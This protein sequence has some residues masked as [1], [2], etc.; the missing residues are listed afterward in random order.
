MVMLRLFRDLWRDAASY[1]TL[2]YYVLVVLCWI[3]YHILP[4]SKRWIALL[5]GS[6]FFYYLA[7]DKDLRTMAVLAASILISYLGGIL[8]SG[9]QNTGTR[10]AI[11]TAS[12]T[13]SSLPLL[14]YKSNDL[15]FQPVLRHDLQSLIVPL[16]V[17]FYTLQMISYLADIYTGKIQPQR[18]IA[19][20]TLYV[21]F[22]PTVVQG[23]IARYNDMADTLYEGHPFSAE[24]V[25]RGAQLVVWGF[26]LK[27]M[28]A[29]R[30]GIVVDTIFATPEMYLGVYALIGGILYSIQLYTDFLACVCMSRGVAEAF[31][32]HLP[33]NFERP[34]HATSVQDFWRRWHISLSSWL[35]DYVYIPLGGSRKGQGRKY[36]NLILTFLVSGLWHGN[37][38][39][40]LFWGLLH[41]GYQIVGSLTEPFRKRLRQKAGFIEDSAVERVWRSIWT[42]LLVMLAWIIFRADSLTH[43]LLMVRSIFTVYNPWVLGDESLLSLG[44]EWSEWLVLILSIL[45]LAII[46]RYQE[47]YRIR[48][49]ILSMPLFIRWIIYLAAIA[50]IIIFGTYGYGF[51]ASDFIYRGF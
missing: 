13:I 35:R 1:T 8:L 32:I 17:S 36:L 4:R 34:Y 27:Y 31:G 38:Y 24:D 29:D 21:S 43:G 51:N 44:L 10:K 40:F 9:S 15:L 25:T 2:S 6:V 12:I 23:P 42:C 48:D 5:G 14:L 7:S 46:E 39:R 26:F 37:G 18:N 33:E 19:R 50:I 22:F 41:A 45:L 47:T 30:A 20:Y 16:G 28:I 3:V 11:L 49:E